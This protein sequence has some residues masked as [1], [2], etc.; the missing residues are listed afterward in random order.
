[1]QQRLQV[2]AAGGVRV[3]RRRR[4]RERVGEAGELRCSEEDR[5]RAGVG[6][7]PARQVL[8]QV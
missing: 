2:G 3:R 6:A 8:Q 4:E 7:L 1:V 5:A